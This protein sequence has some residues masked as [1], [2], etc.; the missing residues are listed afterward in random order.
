MTMRANHAVGHSMEFKC[1]TIKGSTLI[2]LGAFAIPFLIG[3]YITTTWIINNETAGIYAEGNPVIASLYTDHGYNG[4]LMVKVATFLMIG[5]T[6]YLID[7]K[8]CSRLNRLKEWALLVL[9]GFYMLVVL[10]NTLI[11]FALGKI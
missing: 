9:I 3:D 1:G 5:A 4:L 10:N 11:I 7:M 2:L 8:F 6:A